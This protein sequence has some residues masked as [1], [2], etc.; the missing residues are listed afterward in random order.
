MALL[1]SYTATRLFTKTKVHC[2]TLHGGLCLVI[3]VSKTKLRRNTFKTHCIFWLFGK[4]TDYEILF[5]TPRSTSLYIFLL[6]K[7]T[8]IQKTFYFTLNSYKHSL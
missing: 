5:L 3:Y 2:N 7:L 4:G 8:D 6:Q 1:V